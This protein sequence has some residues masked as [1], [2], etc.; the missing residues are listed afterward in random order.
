MCTGSSVRAV[1]VLHIHPSLTGD[2]FRQAWILFRRE[3]SVPP[4]AERLHLKKAESSSA[5]TPAAVGG[6]GDTC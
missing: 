4:P 6:E 5:S 1:R 2:E 3:T